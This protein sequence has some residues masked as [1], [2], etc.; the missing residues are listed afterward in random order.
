MKRYLSLFLA[1]VMLLGILPCTASAAAAGDKLTFDDL[2]V[3]TDLSG[4]LAS[5]TTMAT[6]S[7]AFAKSGSNS[8]EL[9]D[10]S[11]TSAAIMRYSGKKVGKQVLEFEL[12]MLSGAVGIRLSNGTRGT[13]NTAFWLQFINVK[14]TAA[15]GTVSYPTHLQYHDG[16]KW[17]TLHNFGTALAGKW[18]SVRVE[19]D[20]ANTAKIYVGGQLLGEAPRC[21]S[22]DYGDNAKTVIDSVVFEAGAA[23]ATGGKCHI[24]D[25]KLS[26]VVDTVNESFEGMEVGTVP[27]SPFS[28]VVMATVE[29]A[30]KGNTKAVYLNDTVS[31]DVA[32]LR[33]SVDKTD[34]LIVDFSVLPVSGA[35]QLRLTNGARSTANTGFW[36]QFVNVKGADN[37]YYTHLKYYS[38]TAWVDEYTFSESLSNNWHNIHIEAEPGD[39]AKVM[40]DS[41]LIAEIP[42]CTGTY[43]TNAQNELDSVIFECGTAS[44]TGNRYY[45]DNV[46]M[47]EVSPLDE[48]F[49]A[50]ELTANAQGLPGYVS[51]VATQVTAAPLREGGKALYMADENQANTPAFE[52]SFSLNEKYTLEFEVLIPTAN[53]TVTFQIHDGSTEGNTAYFMQF[54]HQYG[55]R[56]FGGNW[57]DTTSQVWSVLNEEVKL[58]A[59]VWNKIRIEVNTEEAGEALIYVNGALVGNT[60]VV[61]GKK[62]PVSGMHISLGTATQSAYLDNIRMTPAVEGAEDA[63]GANKL[64]FDDKDIGSTPATADGFTSFLATEVKAAPDRSGNALWLGDPAGKTRPEFHYTFDSTENLVLEFD[65]NALDRNT[66]SVLRIYNGAFTSTNTALWLN[67]NVSGLRYYDGGWSEF[68]SGVVT[69]ANTW[70]HVRI[71]LTTGATGQAKVYMDGTLVLTVPA[72]SSIGKGAPSVNNVMFQMTNATKSCYIDNLSVTAKQAGQLDPTAAVEEDFESVALT[73]PATVVP[74]HKESHGANVTYDPADDEGK[75]LLLA[76]MTATKSP[77]IDC[78]FNALDKMTFQ[79]DLY[80]PSTSTTVTLQLYNGSRSYGS[81]AFCLQFNY[82]YGLRIYDGSKYYILNSGVKFDKNV[83]NNIVIEMTT[84]E[85]SQA[86]IYVNGLKVAETDV[87]CANTTPETVNGFYMITGGKDQKAYIDNLKLSSAVDV[88]W[89]VDGREIVAPAYLGSIPTFPGT[90]EKAADEAHHYVFTDWDKTVDASS[91][92]DTY[93]ANFTAVAHEMGNFHLETAPGLTADGAEVATCECG[94]EIGR[95]VS[96]PQGVELTETGAKLTANAELAALTVEDGKTL[97]LNGHTLTVNDLACF[98][99][100]TGTGVLQAENLLLSDLAAMP[101][102]DSA[103]GG[104]Q[105]FSYEI[106]SL[107]VRENKDGSVSYGFA[108]DFAHKDAYKLLAELDSGAQLQLQLAWGENSKTLAFAPEYLSQYAKL[109]MQYPNA[110]AAL[111]L[112]VTGMGSDALTVTPAVVSQ[113]VTAAGKALTYE[114][115]GEDEMMDYVTIQADKTLVGLGEQLNLAVT[116]VADKNGNA[117]T[118]YT[119]QWRSL[120]PGVAAVDEN[121]VVS[122]LKAGTAKLQAIVTY[123]GEKRISN[124]VTVQ[125]CDRAAITEM[126]AEVTEFAPKVGQTGNVVYSA[127]NA[128]GDSVA[129]TWSFASS[130]AQVVTVADNGSYTAVAAGKAELIITAQAGG[131]SLSKT[132]TITV[133][134]VWDVDGDG[135][136]EI[137]AVGNS[138]SVDALEYAYQIAQDLGIQKVVLGNLFIGGCSLETHADNAAGDVGAYTY[139][140]NEDGKWSLTTNYKSSTALDSRSW[141]FVSLQQASG[142]SGLADTYNE[143]LEYL[144]DYVQTHTNAKLVWHMTWAYQGN[145]NQSGFTNYGKNQLTMYN[146]IL[147][148]VQTKILTNENFDIIVPNGTVVQNSRTSLLGDTTTRDGYHMSYNFGRYMIGLSFIKAVTGLDIDNVTFT[149][150]GVSA[151]EKAIAIESVNNAAKNPFEITQSEY[152]K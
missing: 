97:D 57:E 49:E 136:L 100:I 20:V 45:I 22:G 109:Q 29:N 70:V 76:D 69:T 23:A 13:A 111:I 41:V 36:M 68:T 128:F 95:S 87:I 52:Y 132:I 102:Y 142:S 107:G 51:D 121:G 105:F 146:G 3:G 145:C 114:K 73:V 1:F 74:G 16:A 62:D 118:G 81:T 47:G 149:S 40:V 60:S 147:D 125:V 131:V 19:V 50:V 33:A 17:T 137:L 138:F 21:D 59:N 110:Q 89:V 43:G 113:G 6:V 24:D 148:A 116:Q 31:A 106:K 88:T 48:N 9:H 18:Q 7:N 38:G 143:D 94:Y 120:N 124:D 152:T 35:V 150:D 92:G 119:V 83:W 72:P 134:P 104:Y 117:V 27:G 115:E 139:Y 65:I 53:N 55:L 96:L 26:A 4:I 15:D 64:T 86:I 42:A 103:T 90:P 80:I 12:R 14:T 54:N 61:Y 84:G 39:K 126:N 66:L 34:A 71:E 56:V 46:M 151:Q 78:N 63:S 37:V 30:S 82:A 129:A 108:L 8:A 67:F 11:T 5:G 144:I 99:S 112:G 133:N 58:T 32:L 10:T 140:L 98:G 85:D 91:K 77:Y 93:T 79:F 130:N 123:N 141:D 75:A 28:D 2:A 122:T 127:Y 44:S 135:V 101:L 25:V